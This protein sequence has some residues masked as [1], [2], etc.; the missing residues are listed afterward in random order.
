MG[1]KPDPGRPGRPGGLLLRLH[2]RVQVR[3][4]LGRFPGRG[5]IRPHGRTHA[6]RREPHGHHHHLLRHHRPGAGNRL[7]PGKAFKLQAGLLVRHLLRRTFPKHTAADPALFLELRPALR[8]SRR[9]P[10]QD[11]RDGFRILGLHPGL[12]HL[13]RRLHGRDH[14]R[15][16]PVDPQGTPGG[17]LLVRADL[18]P[19]P[20]QDHPAPWPSGRSFRPW[21]ANS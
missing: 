11:I 13:H 21:A 20:A 18:P 4:R 16:H 15:G 3:L 8:L 6:S 12:R 2:L 14:P 9:H 17:L 10:R 7:R 19:D 5:T 1:A